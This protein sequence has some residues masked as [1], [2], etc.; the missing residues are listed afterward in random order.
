MLI[1]YKRKTCDLILKKPGHYSDNQLVK[2]LSLVMGH[3]VSVSFLI[4]CTEK[5]QQDFHITVKNYNQ[6]HHE[7]PSHKPNMKSILQN[8]DLYSSK[9]TITKGTTSNKSYSILKRKNTYVTQM[10]HLIKIASWSRK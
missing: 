9:I 2:V 3:R 10:K 1:N 4:R 8:A 5:A 7:G 6:L